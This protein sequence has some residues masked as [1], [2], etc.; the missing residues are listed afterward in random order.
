MYFKKMALQ[1]FCY[2]HKRV[3]VSLTI[4]K[5]IT[6]ASSYVQHGGKGNRSTEN[7]VSLSNTW[8]LRTK[9]K[10]RRV[11]REEE[12]PISTH[13]TKSPYNNTEGIFP[14]FELLFITPM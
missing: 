5:N 6:C 11:S 14:P 12:I 1:M 8:R 3:I 9:K 7:P 13:A 4:D 2:I 10:K